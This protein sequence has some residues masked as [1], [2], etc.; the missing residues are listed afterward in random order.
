MKKLIKSRSKS[1]GYLAVAGLTLVVCSLIVNEVNDY[2]ERKIANTLK[3]NG[4][5]SV[6]KSNYSVNNSDNRNFE[7][8]AVNFSSVKDVLITMEDTYYGTY[9]SDVLSEV[10]NVYFPAKENLYSNVASYTAYASGLTMEENENVSEGE[11]IKDKDIVEEEVE[12]VV[13][14]CTLK[15]GKKYSITEHEYD[16]LTRLVQCEA[17]GEDYKGKVLVANVVLNR[18]SSKS[19]PNTIEKVVFEKKNGKYQ[20][21]PAKRKIY[22]AKVSAETKK[23]VDAALNGTD[24]S[25]GAL[26][27]ASTRYANTSWFDRCLK[28]VVTHGNHAFYK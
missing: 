27:F 4:I 23:A 6:K 12:Q 14:D 15:S 19:F 3:S 2:N 11:E 26:Y 5:T 10:E 21:Q 25:N 1:A 22:K 7:E 28:H 17:S 16:V 13:A 8:V 18:V 20:F 24:Y 9:A